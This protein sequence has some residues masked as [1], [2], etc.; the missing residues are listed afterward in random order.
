MFLIIYH[1]LF[2]LK[3]EYKINNINNLLNTIEK[4]NVNPKNYNKNLLNY[5]KIY[6]LLSLDNILIEEME[7]RLLTKS[8]N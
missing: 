3:T 8:L 6:G 7:S 2:T 5:I 4:N 1:L